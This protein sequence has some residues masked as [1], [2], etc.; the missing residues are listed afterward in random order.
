MATKKL[1]VTL[2]YQGLNYEF[3]D[4]VELAKPCHDSG[5]DEKRRTRD[6]SWPGLTQAGADA[7]VKKLKALKGPRRR[8]VVG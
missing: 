3:D 8:I 2:T 1:T 5:Y 4:D 7:L 6:F